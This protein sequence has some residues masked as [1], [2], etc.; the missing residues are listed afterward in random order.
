MEINLKARLN[1]QVF[2]GAF[3]YKGKFLHTI[4]LRG[5]SESNDFAIVQIPL[6]TESPINTSSEFISVLSSIIDNDLPFYPCVGNGIAL[7]IVDG[8]LEIIE[9]YSNTGIESHIFTIDTI[10]DKII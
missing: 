3:I 1:A 6:A 8:N 9:S 4:T 7:S 10:K 2:A 5:N